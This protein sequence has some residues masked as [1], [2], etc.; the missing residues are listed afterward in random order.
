MIYYGING[1]LDPPSYVQRN[2]T[3]WRLI[4]RILSFTKHRLVV[5][6]INLVE[7]Q[8]IKCTKE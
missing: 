6:D 1:L 4:I 8:N 5:A 7:E 2:L 3:L